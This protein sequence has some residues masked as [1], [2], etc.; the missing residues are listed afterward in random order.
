MNQLLAS[1]QSLF[2]YFDF[3]NIEGH[4]SDLL[5]VFASFIYS[6]GNRKGGKDKYASRV[7]SIFFPNEDGN[8]ENLKNVKRVQN[9][10]Q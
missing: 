9:L 4:F 1:I 2:H 6:R 5:I 10:V 7:D 3:A 8:A